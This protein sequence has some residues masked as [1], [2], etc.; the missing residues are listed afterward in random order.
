VGKNS[1]GLHL[2]HEEHDCAGWGQLAVGW[3]NADGSVDAAFD[4]EAGCV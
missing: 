3:L 2:A 1:P 4:A